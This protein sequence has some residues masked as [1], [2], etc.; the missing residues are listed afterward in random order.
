MSIVGNE[1]SNAN[2]MI[3]ID[4]VLDMCDLMDQLP[5]H[6]L[7]TVQLG[8]R[9]EDTLCLYLGKLHDLYPTPTKPSW[10]W[11]LVF[12]LAGSFGKGETDSGGAG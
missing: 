12:S 5:R 8:E 2:A 10:F 11:L 3:V 6:L 7:P 1:E 4:S 9:N